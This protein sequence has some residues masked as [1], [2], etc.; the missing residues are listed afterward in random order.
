MA[1]HPRDDDLD[2]VL[3]LNERLLSRRTLL[4]GL[5]VGGAVAM[6]SGVLAGCGT[7]G[8]KAKNEDKVVKDLS[9]TEKKVVWS[10][11]PLLLDVDD[12]TKKHPTLE[13]FQQQSGISV[14]YTEDIN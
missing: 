1:D 9:A 3:R 5:G 12:K 4:R 2:L 13:A 6:S 10:N 7:S 11:W 8:G 14:T